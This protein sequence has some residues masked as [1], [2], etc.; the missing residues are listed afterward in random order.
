MN[1]AFTPYES[2]AGGAGVANVV[3]KAKGDNDRASQLTDIAS[4]ART[5]DGAWTP[6]P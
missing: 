3:Y 2:R 6:E 5:L 4:D 1:E